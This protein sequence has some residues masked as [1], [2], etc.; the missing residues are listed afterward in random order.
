MSSRVE[1]EE[2]LRYTE[3]PTREMAVRVKTSKVRSCV[4]D[5]RF[6]SR[7]IID[8]SGIDGQYDFRLAF[9]AETDAGLPQAF[10]GNA[11]LIRS[12]TVLLRSGKEIRPAHRASEGDH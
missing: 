8:A 3:M 1:I 7:P 2:Y 11:A 12:C 10:Q 9:A 5:S 6:T 4:A